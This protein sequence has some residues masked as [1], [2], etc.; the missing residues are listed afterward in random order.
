[1]LLCNCYWYRIFVFRHCIYS[2]FR[3]VNTSATLISRQ[4]CN[5]RALSV[6]TAV[7]PVDRGGQ[8][9]D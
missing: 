1:M 5:C 3:K 7:A 4:W 2:L 8:L 9:K 6:V